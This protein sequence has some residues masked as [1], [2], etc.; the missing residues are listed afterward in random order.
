MLPFALT[1]LALFIVS[2][3]RGDGRMTGTATILGI[4]WLVEVGAVNLTGERFPWMLFLTVDY[5]SALGILGFAAG[6]WQAAIIGIYA[7]QIV[8]H[9]GYGLSSEGL[10]AQYRYYWALTYT[11]WAQL[12]VLGGWCIY[13]LVGGAGGRLGGLTI[14]FASRCS[15]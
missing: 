14:S 15:C 5:L 4:N 2:A 13:A 8:C 1:I 7:T 11:G 9:A 3:I 12:A 10:W 6:R